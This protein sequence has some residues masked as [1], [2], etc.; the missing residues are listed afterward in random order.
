VF[1]FTSLYT[2]DFSLWPQ[3]REYFQFFL[4]A[5]RGC[6]TA[7]AVT[8]LQD[9]GEEEIKNRPFRSVKS[10]IKTPDTLTSGVS[11]V[12][13]F[14]HLRNLYFLQICFLGEFTQYIGLT[15]FLYFH[16]TAR[17]QTFQD[18]MFHKKNRKKL[19]EVSMDKEIMNVI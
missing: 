4:L 15:P 10:K 7:T 6:S 1:L 9:S 2:L 13:G 12:V 14:L 3:L 11:E 17:K 18:G 5:R 19:E 16:N 8:D